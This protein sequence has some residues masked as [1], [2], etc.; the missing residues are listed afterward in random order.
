L[1]PPC[2]LQP[3]LAT[4]PPLALLSGSL[5]RMGSGEKSKEKQM[6]EKLLDILAGSNE[7][8]DGGEDLS[9]IQINAEYARR[10]EHNKRLEE[11][12]KQGLVPA[13]DDDESESESES[14]EEED[15]EATI[16]SRLVDRRVFEVIRR[17]RSGDPRILDKDAELYSEDEDEEGGEEA[18]DAEKEEESKQEKKKTK[19]EK[20]MYLKD[21]NARH[22]LEEGPEFAAQSSRSSSK[23]ER[24]AY[25][26]QQKKGLEAFLEAQKEV[27]GDGDDDDDL[28]QVKPKA[29]AGA[30]DEAEE[31]EEEKPATACSEL[32]ARS[33]LVCERWFV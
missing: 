12:R 4:L 25:D 19:K 20:P 7:D 11:R 10:F 24:I 28:F 18:E 16:A 15:E 23:F 9:K 6:E 13:S 32:L 26:E 5:K 8:S 29:R 30:D 1:P 17:I 33:S 21:V 3:S 14:S 22:L 2:S 27:L 31:D